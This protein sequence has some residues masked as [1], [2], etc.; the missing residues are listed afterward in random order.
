MSLSE[1]GD[2]VNK[3]LWASRSCN[4]FANH[5]SWVQ[6]PVGMVL[7]TEL[8]TGYHH[9]STYTKLSVCLCVWKIGEGFPGQVSPKTLK[10]VAVYSS[11]TFHING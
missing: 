6:G 5:R 8:P 11:K 9:T 7:S 10:W 4:G 3:S 2:A 1:I